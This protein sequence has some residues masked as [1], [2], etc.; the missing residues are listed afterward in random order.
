MAKITLEDVVNLTNENSAVNAFRVNNDT[1]ETAFENTLSRDGTAPNQMMADFDM[2]SHRILNLPPPATDTEPLRRADFV[3]G[4]IVGPQGEKGDKGDTAD[5]AAATAPYMLTNGELLIDTLNEGI[6]PYTANATYENW[7]IDGFRIYA[8]GGTP[9]T[10]SIQQ[11][12]NVGP[13]QELPCSLWLRSGTRNTAPTAADNYHIEQ[14]IIPSLVKYL[15]MGTATAK[16]FTYSFYIASSVTPLTLSWSFL[17]ADNSRSFVGTTTYNVAAN[18]WQRLSVTVPGDTFT[19]SAYSANGMKII[20]DL[21]FGSN[22]EQVAASTVW[23]TGAKF[24]V[25]GSYNYI[26]AASPATIFLTGEQI[27]YGSQALDFR[28]LSLET[29]LRRTR[30]FKIKSAPL[31]TPAIAGQGPDSSLNYVTQVA[32]AHFNNVTYDYPAEMWQVP[33]VNILNPNAGGTAG[34]FADLSHVDDSG[35][36]SVYNVTTKRVTLLNPGVAGDADQQLNGVAFWLGACPGNIGIGT[37][38]SLP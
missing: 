26:Q 29:H 4:G 14:W 11:V 38:A 23:Q 13:S 35:T 25:A 30:M 24:R 34:K 31:G 33:V 27:D 7:A 6:N 22:F 37:G 17:P 16:T 8:G 9:G 3:D 19:T 20:L 5:P 1:L 28:P 10:F 18:N 36:A 15:N 2:N 12:N 32:G 21:G